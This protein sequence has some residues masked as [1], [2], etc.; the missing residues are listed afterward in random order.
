MQKV[1]VY[2]ACSFDGY[3]AGPGDDI[4]WL[5]EDHSSPGALPEDPEAL[6]FEAFMSQV[7]AMLMGRTTYEVVEGFA[8]W[9]YGETPV[10]VATHRALEP[11]APTVRAAAGDIGELVAQAKEA[12][13]ARDVY[14][15][16]C[17]LIQQALAAGLVDEMTLTLIP[18]ILGGGTRLFDGTAPR[19][20][21]VFGPSR[22][23]SRGMMQVTATARRDA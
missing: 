20:A 13:G 6:G 1:R 14:L 3:I 10:I 4:A 8:Q 5:H 21:L 23:F 22:A 19:Q 7:G 16:G 2:M 15:D 12:A 17:A 9:P 11:T 18:V